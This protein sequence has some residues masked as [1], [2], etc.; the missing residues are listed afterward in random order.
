MTVPLLILSLL[1]SGP[2]NVLSPL[3]SGPVNAG[4]IDSVYADGRDRWTLL[5]QKLLNRQLFLQVGDD[6][7]AFR[8]GRDLDPFVIA[9][10]GG[11][12]AQVAL[13]ES[14]QTRFHG[15]FLLESYVGLRLFDGVEVNVNLNLLNPSASD[16]YRF[17]SQ[18][19]AGLALHIH[20]EVAEL[21]GE[22]VVLDFL[23]LDLDLV[24]LSQGLL[25]ERMPLE[26]HAASVRWGPVELRELFA[27]RTFWY[28]DDLQTVSLRI[29]DGLVEAMFVAW[30]TEDVEPG[31]SPDVDISSTDVSVPRAVAYYAGIAGNWQIFESLRIGVEYS[32]RIRERVLRNAAMLRVDFLDTR[33]TSRWQLHVGYQLRF[34]ERGFGP[35]GTLVTPTAL[36][37]LPFR[38]D[39][40]VTNSFEVLSI[41][42]FYTQLSHTAML[43]TRIGINDRLTVFADVEYWARWLTD[44]RRGSDRVVYVSRFG[45]AP[46]WGDEIYFRAGLQ[47]QPWSTS[48][49]RLKVYA[50]NKFVA[51]SFDA[52]TPDTRRFEQDALVVLEVEVYL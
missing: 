31:V 46:G 1:G 6:S 16:G 2:V 42:R 4:A 25:I 9:A 34:Y 28:D 17:S 19:N 12:G 41:S 37:N 20:Q 13:P 38:E 7:Q 8:L 21:A 49:H 51:S 44:P 22:P 10:D 39:A 24:T 11:V 29:W 33:L 30:L 52:T 23:A 5:D 48:P 26:G 36:P 32:G 43:E 15:F 50:G 45:R 47:L 18:V 14:Q 27:G 40:Y 3:G 35:R